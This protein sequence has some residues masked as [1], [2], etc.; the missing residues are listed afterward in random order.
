MWL[1]HVTPWRV[2]VTSGEHA[3]VGRNRVPLFDRARQERKASTSHERLHVRSRTRAAAN[4]GAIPST[5]TIT[6]CRMAATGRSVR[7]PCPR[8]GATQMTV[9]Q[10]QS[11]SRFTASSAY[12]LSV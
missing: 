2:G 11:L 8:S 1:S 3:D 10:R 6:A 7:G 4:Q 5:L 12:L 9:A